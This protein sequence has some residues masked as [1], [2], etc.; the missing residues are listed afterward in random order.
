[1]VGVYHNIIRRLIKLKTLFIYTKNIKTKE[2]KTFSV[3]K[4]R[5]TNRNGDT[6]YFDTVLTEALNN[7]IIKQDLKMPIEMVVEDNQY[8]IKNKTIRRPNGDTF[9]KHVLYIKDCV[10]MVQGQFEDLTIDDIDVA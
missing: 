6:I 10:S 2:G 8:Y 3:T 5:T 7:K 4:A 1:M 9:K